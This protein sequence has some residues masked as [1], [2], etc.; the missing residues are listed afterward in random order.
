[1]SSLYQKLSRGNPLLPKRYSRNN[2][3]SHL[4]FTVLDA[5]PENVDACLAL[6]TLLKDTDNPGKALEVIN[7]QLEVVGTDYKSGQ[8]DLRI[9]VLKCFILYTLAQFE[10]FIELALVIVQ[11][12]YL[13]SQPSSGRVGNR[14]II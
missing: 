3:T 7:K 12:P 1:V 14:E 8:A 4:L 5:I 11:D 2:A 6:A 10:Q 9:L 13:R